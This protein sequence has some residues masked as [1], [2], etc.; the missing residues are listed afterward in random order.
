MRV[1]TLPEV[2][3][4]PKILSPDA[5]FHMDADTKERSR[6]DIIF[7][8]LPPPKLVSRS[9]INYTNMVGVNVNVNGVILNNAVN[10]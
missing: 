10:F 2:P 7:Y 6:V 1:Q 4:A 8:W 3:E 9:D 5:S